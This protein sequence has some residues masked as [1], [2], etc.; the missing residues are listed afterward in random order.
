[1]IAWLAHTPLGWELHVS[2]WATAGLS[3]LAGTW[4]IDR[5]FSRHPPRF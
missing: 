2:W 4:A 1:V 5:W 3:F